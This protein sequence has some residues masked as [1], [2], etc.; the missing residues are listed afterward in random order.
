MTDFESTGL[1]TTSSTNTSLMRQQKYRRWIELNPA[2]QSGEACLNGTRIP[3]VQ[4]ALGWWRGW[5]LDNLAAEFQ[6]VDRA[7]LLVACWYAGTYGEPK[8]Q[9]RFGRWAKKAQRQLW[10]VLNV[11]VEDI[12]LPP[13]QDSPE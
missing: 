13:Q 3:A 8:L 5:T 9:T 11:D 4:I 10:D 1:I 2:K 6:C 7:C 12:P